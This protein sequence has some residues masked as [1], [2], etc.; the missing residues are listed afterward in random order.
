MSLTSSPTKGRSVFGVESIAGEL[1]A[2]EVIVLDEGEE[3][4]VVRNEVGGVVGRAFLGKV[5]ETRIGSSESR[6][7]EAMEGRERLVT[8]A[9][10]LDIGRLKSVRVESV[11]RNLGRR[12]SCKKI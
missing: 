10:G 8:V 9:G 7:C 6:R 3:V 1:V 2:I 4:E 5:V 11:R 12:L